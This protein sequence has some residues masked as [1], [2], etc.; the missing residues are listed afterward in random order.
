MKIAAA[1]IFA[2]ALPMAGVA[3]AAQGMAAPAAGGFTVTV[4]ITNVRNAKGR[5]HVDLCRQKE[6]LKDCPIRADGKAVQGTTILTVHHVPAGDYGAQTS[7][8]ENLNGKVDQGLFGIPKEGIGFSNDAPIRLAPPRWADAVFSVA[9][10]RT[11]KIKTR[12]ML[13]GAG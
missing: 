2:L 1:L 3:G 7:H 11:I 9:S 13:G 4:E 8:D 10:D 12:Y 6:F 5:V